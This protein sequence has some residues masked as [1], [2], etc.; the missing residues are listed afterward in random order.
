MSR[1]VLYK[2]D[3][4]DCGPPSP[5]DAE[6]HF[7]IVMLEWSNGIAYRMGTY[8]LTA[9]DTWFLSP[10]SARIQRFAFR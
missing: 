9:K 7:Y 3:E 8:T 4:T 10:L 2:V 1:D 5:P 6:I